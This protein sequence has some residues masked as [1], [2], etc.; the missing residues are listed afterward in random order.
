M[1]SKH[2]E[3]QDHSQLVVSRCSGTF[4]II[5]CE[6]TKQYST[7]CSNRWVCHCPLWQRQQ[8]GSHDEGGLSSASPREI[9]SLAILIDW[10]GSRC[11]VRASGS[12]EN[13]VP[14]NSDAGT[15]CSLVV[16]PATQDIDI[17]ALEV[18]LEN[19]HGNA[20]VYWRRK[21]Y[22]D[23]KRWEPGNFLYEN[24]TIRWGKLSRIYMNAV[25]K[26]N[27]LV[28]LVKMLQY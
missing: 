15:C 5:S 17:F 24:T 11:V 26:L 28:L 4:L 9:P 18:S 13:T 25:N 6:Q 10:S 14:G 21:Q 3:R 22:L 27:V 2:H 1:T 12:S 7:P 16:D 8:T 20:V 23:S 19:V